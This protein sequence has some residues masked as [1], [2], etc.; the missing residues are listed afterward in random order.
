MAALYLIEILHQTTTSS[1]ARARLLCCILLKFYIKPQQPFTRSRY[2]KLY[3]IE[4]LHQTTTCGKCEDCL[5]RLY[6]IE[7]LH[8]TTTPALASMPLCRCILLKFYIKPQ[9]RL[10]R[11]LAYCVVSYRNSTSNHNEG[12]PLNTQRKLY[13]IEILH[14]TTTNRPC[15][16]RSGRCILSKFYI[17]PQRITPDYLNYQ[18]CILSKFYI[19]PQQRHYVRRFCVV[20]SYRNSTSNHNRR[21]PPSVPNRVVSYRNSTSNHNFQYLFVV[22]STLYLIEILHQTTTP[23]PKNIHIQRCILSKFYIKPQHCV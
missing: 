13:L 22:I 7:I 23:K 8:Q 17:K 14:Q 21:S 6:L 1:R 10:E 3:L 15:C 11:E 2:S 5:R 4:I 12:E 18:G 16:R 9:L 19:K 20:V